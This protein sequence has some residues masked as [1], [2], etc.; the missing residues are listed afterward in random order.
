MSP[1]HLPQ[2]AGNEHVQQRARYEH[3]ETV[4]MKICRDKQLVNTRL[5]WQTSV[6]SS[7]TGR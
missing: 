5:R 4:L 2:P 3:D 6:S 1:D 7:L